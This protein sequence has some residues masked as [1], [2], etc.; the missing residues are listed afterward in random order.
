MRKREFYFDI[1]SAMAAARAL[2]LETRQH[3]AI[4][5]FRDRLTLELVFMPAAANPMWT[6]R[7]DDRGL[8]HEGKRRFYR[9]VDKTDR[10][11]IRQLHKEGLS[12]AEIARKFE[13]AQPS[14][15]NIVL[16]QA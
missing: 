11:L 16:A 1:P 3:W 15:R 10:P 8:A 4:I 2:R 5:Q 12:I 9:K 7:E 13:V 14:I 6:T